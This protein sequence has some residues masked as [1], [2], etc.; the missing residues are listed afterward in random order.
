MPQQHVD[1]PGAP[2]RLALVAVLDVAWRV[3][4]LSLHPLGLPTLRCNIAW[5]VPTEG[6]QGASC[7]VPDGAGRLRLEHQEIGDSRE[8]VSADRR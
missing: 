7:S 4:L 8:G 3:N 2:P 6:G 5:V 1:C